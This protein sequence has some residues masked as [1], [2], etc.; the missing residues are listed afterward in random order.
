V[1]GG[2]V[3][4]VTGAAGFLGSHV[5]RVLGAR[6][7]QVLGCGRGTEA[8]ELTRENLRRLAAHADTIVHCAGG[9]SVGRSLV[10]PVRDLDDT[11]G[12][13]GR[14]LDFVRAERPG[15]AVV[16]VSSAAVY[17]DCETLP[18]AESTCLLP[19]SPYGVH[20]QL[21]EEL[22]RAHGRL[23]G[24]RGAIVRFFSLY[25]PGLQKQLLWDACGKATRG[26]RRFSGTGQELRDWLHVDDACALLDAVAAVATPSVPVYNGAAGV[27]VTVAEVLGQVY[28]LLEVALP[29]E[30]DGVVR[31]GDPR[32]YVADIGR[33]RALGWTPRLGLA[34]GLAEY[35]AWFRQRS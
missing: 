11:L 1:F 4:V 12:S 10:D 18:I 15:A 25:G 9:S 14:V 2:N 33:A 31:A 30:F 24:T 7:H 34:Q 28:R 19:V 5:C 3:V 35:V 17:G 8:A 29:P 27:G 16:L 23:H 6:G 13:L 21:A 20:K 22:L 32:H 26:E